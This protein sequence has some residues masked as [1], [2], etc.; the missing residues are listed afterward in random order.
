MK[1]NSMTKLMKAAALTSL[2]AILSTPVLADSDDAKSESL[3]RQIEALQTRIAALEARQTFTAF[4]PDLA[5]RF[6]VMHRAGD[7]G[8]W[9]M[10]SHELEEMKRLGRLS[11]SIDSERGKLLQAMMGPSFEALGTAI[12]RSDHKQFRK[13]LPQTIDS[14][15]ACHTATDSAFV[16]VTLDVRDSL[17][18]RHPHMFMEQEVARG[19][20]H[21]DTPDESA[22]GEHDDTGKAAHDDAPEAAHD[23]TGKAAHND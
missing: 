22:T 7:A 21:G 1:E 3:E 2:V 19:H 20:G 13:A 8:D 10:A 16:M 9:A 5:E 15:N 18:I 11:T 12:E 14:C 23:D 17:S 6:H 4:M